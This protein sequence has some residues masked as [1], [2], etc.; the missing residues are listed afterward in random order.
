[1]AIPIAR[2]RN[3]ESEAYSARVAGGADSEERKDDTSFDEG[4]PSLRESWMGVGIADGVVVL[5][6]GDARRCLGKAPGQARWVP[7]RRE[8]NNESEAYS[9]RVAGGADSEERKDDTSFDE[10]DP[11]LRESWMGV[12]IADGVAMP[13]DALVKHQAKLDGS[14]GGGEL[15]RGF[16]SDLAKR[17]E[18]VEAM[19]MPFFGD[20]E[21]P[22]G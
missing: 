15:G 1:M 13:D 9:A 19:S 21:V 5:G 22:A 17:R 10:G 14:L 8:R 20:W 18:E 7:W 16:D 3:N 12:G 2:E 11:S 6:L 4:D